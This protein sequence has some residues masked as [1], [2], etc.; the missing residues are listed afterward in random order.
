MRYSFKVLEKSG[1]SKNSEHCFET[2]ELKVELQKVQTLTKKPGW[3]L[4][5]AFVKVLFYAKRR[6]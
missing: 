6:L 5:R 1:L 2:D 4:S 3:N